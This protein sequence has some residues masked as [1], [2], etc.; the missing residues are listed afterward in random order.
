ML[1]LLLPHVEFAYNSLV[2][3]NT[4]RSPFEVITVNP[5][6]LVDLVSFPITSRT[7]QGVVDFVPYLREVHAK[8]R[9]QIEQSNA[10]YK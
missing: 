2:N 1:D 10:S 7:S 6:G 8:I 3:Y 9:T 4:W 5:Q